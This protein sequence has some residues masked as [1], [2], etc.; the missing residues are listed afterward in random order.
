MNQSNNNRWRLDGKRAVV[1]GATKGIGQAIALELGALGAEVLIVARNAEEVENLISEQRA[2]GF[3]KTYGIAAD[4]ASAEGRERIF[5]AVRDNLDGRL[6]VLVNNVGT[7]VRKKALEYSEEEYLRLFNTNVASGW[8]MSRAAHAL[9]RE[10]KGGASIVNITS[11]AGMVALRTGAIYAMTKAAL[12]QLTKNLAVEWAADNIRVNAVAPWF[13]RTPLTETVLANPEFMQ[14][15]LA[16]TPLNRVAEPEEVAG[17]AA[18]L[19]LPAASFITGQIIAD[20]GGF[21]AQ[22]L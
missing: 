21:L 15:V 19:C 20:D 22:G 9:L 4:A 11:V 1:T 10:S 2:H 8:E 6:D 14:N 7:N 16:H 13:T 5:A 17:L 18:F 12:N 3:D